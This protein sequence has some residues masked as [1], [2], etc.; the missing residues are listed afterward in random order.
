[1]AW[2]PRKGERRCGG[3]CLAFLNSLS[4]GPLQAGV[5]PLRDEQLNGIS[6]SDLGLVFQVEPRLS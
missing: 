3:Q 1:M 6:E 2:F 5:D 4:Q